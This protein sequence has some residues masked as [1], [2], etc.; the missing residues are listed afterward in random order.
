MTDWS[1]EEFIGP[2]VMSW[3]HDIQHNDTKLKDTLH[4]NTKLP[5]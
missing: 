1:N 2:T 3:R 4:K 5:H